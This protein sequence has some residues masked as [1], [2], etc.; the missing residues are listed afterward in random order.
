MPL[1]KSKSQRAFKHNIRTEVRAGRP[2]KQA[3]AIAYSVKR[4]NRV[5]AKHLDA[6]AR[7][8]QYITKEAKDIERAVKRLQKRDATMKRRNRS[9]NFPEM[10]SGPMKRSSWGVMPS[11]KEWKTH[12]D[13]YVPGGIYPIRNARELKNRDGDFTSGELRALVKRLSQSPNEDRMSLASGIMETLGFEW[14]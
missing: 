14:I 2:V 13:Y 8:F 4:R 1:W 12:F 5:S 9:G 6:D 7:D 3:V 11:A 10:Y